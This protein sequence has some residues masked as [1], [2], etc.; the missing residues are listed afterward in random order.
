MEKSCEVISNALTTCSIQVHHPTDLSNA[1]PA[2]GLHGSRPTIVLVG[3]AS[4]LSDSYLDS[5][6]QLFVERLAPL[7]EKSGA[8]VVDGGTDSG[9]MRLMGQ[10]RYAING[11]FPLIGV[12]AIG[13]IILPNIKNSFADA[14]PLEPHHSH[15]VLVPGIAWGDESPWMA[16]VANVLADGAPS[17]TILVNGGKIALLDVRYSIVADRPVVVVDGSGRTADLLAAALRGE[18]IDVK[19]L[20][21]AESGKL[22][23]VDLSNGFSPV[24]RAI[25]QM[26]SI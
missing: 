26:L 9:V 5:L 10:A 19:A 2:I 16:Q 14:A 15:F 4:G 8:Y 1:L 20:E 13:T 22:T 21:L 12:A 7:A 25:A 3:G 6:R 11:T 17:V 23:A 18:T 24:A